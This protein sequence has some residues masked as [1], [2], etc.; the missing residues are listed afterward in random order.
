MRNLYVEQKKKEIVDCGEY[1]IVEERC[2]IFKRFVVGVRVEYESYNN[3][4]VRIHTVNANNSMETITGFSNS[5]DAVQIATHI[6]E[7][8]QDNAKL[9]L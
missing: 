6:M 9:L 8:C 1:I 3:Y 2:Y 5:D 7:M 4:F